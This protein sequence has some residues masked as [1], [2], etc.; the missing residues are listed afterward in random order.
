M[1]VTRGRPGKRWVEDVKGNL[2][3]MK[4]KLRRQ[5]TVEREE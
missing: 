4:V 5:K 1:K 3:K 2:R